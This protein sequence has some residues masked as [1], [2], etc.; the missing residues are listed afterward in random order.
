MNEL[1][2][3][4]MILFIISSLYMRPF[5]IK[6]SH[7]PLYM[8]PFN[9]NVMLLCTV[10][11]N[12]EGCGEW[13]PYSVCSMTCGVGHQTR[14]RSCVIDDNISNQ[15]ETHECNTMPC[16]RT[17]T[18]KPRVQGVNAYHYKYIKHRGWCE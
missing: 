11:D 7:L 18:G 2:Y 13:S 3:F 12:D 14:V 6:W 17:C 16:P 15:D 4:L 9:T 1:P 8:R 5:G 10:T